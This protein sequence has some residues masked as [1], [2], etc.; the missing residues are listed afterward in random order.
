MIAVM[1]SS[2]GSRS[3][4]NPTFK[5]CYFLLSEVVVY[6]LVG[7]EMRMSPHLTKV[8]LTLLFDGKI[9]RLR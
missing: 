3:L 2:T 4:I 1:I 7:T 9:Y 6:D 8:C 5:F